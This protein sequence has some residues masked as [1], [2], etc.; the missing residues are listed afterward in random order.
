[1]K[2][3]HSRGPGNFPGPRKKKRE[4]GKKGK[5]RG[6]R[7]EKHLALAQIIANNFGYN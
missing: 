1:M 6:K 5:R 4:G 7:E 2:N 3:C